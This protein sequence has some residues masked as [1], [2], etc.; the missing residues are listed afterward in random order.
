MFPDM[1]EDTVVTELNLRYMNNM[2]L[3]GSFRLED[4]LWG[5]WMREA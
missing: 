1:S 4:T 3:V 5:L 2:T